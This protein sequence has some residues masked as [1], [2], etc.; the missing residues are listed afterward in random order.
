MAWEQTLVPAEVARAGIQV[1]HSPNYILPAALPCAAVVTI[2]DL[3]FRQRSLHRW[4]SRAYLTVMTALALRRASAIIAVS[5]H[6]RR[7]LERHYPRA[8]GRV[9]VIHEGVDPA[10]RAPSPAGLQCFRERLGLSDPYI[11]FVG[12]QEPRKNLVRLVRAFEG[13]IGETGL[14]HR[15]VLAGRAGWKNEPLDRAIEASPARER[16]CRTGYVADGE[17]ACWYAGA[18]VLVYPSLE[19]GFGLPP[20]EAMALG[21][22]VVMSDCPAHLEV[23]ADAALTVNP[24]DVPGMVA[25]MASVLTRPALADQLREEGRARAAR[26]SW[27]EAARRHVAVY[28]R[29][30]LGES[31]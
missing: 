15:L 19:E 12:T 22:P 4:K 17:L 8:A 18:D 23:A 21:T 28:E 25:A 2:H 6:T 16:I 24:Y 26:F 7:L 10:L 27:E 3:A 13:L 20:L 29:V 31:R 5:E 14:P 30:A 11:L 9:E 1:Y